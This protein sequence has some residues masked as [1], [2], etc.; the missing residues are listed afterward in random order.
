[1]KYIVKLD[2]KSFIFHDRTEALD[3]AD[4]AADAAERPISVSIEVTREGVYHE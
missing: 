1:M 4:M 2:Y 3:F